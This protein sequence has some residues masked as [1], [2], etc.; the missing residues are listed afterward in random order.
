MS[1]DSCIE[2]IG[3][4]LKN[5]QNW[6]EIADPWFEFIGN[7]KPV[8][9]KKGGWR[10]VFF[11]GQKVRVVTPDRKKEKYVEVTDIIVYPPVDNDIVD[12]PLIRYLSAEGIGN[13]LP[14]ITSM[15]DA[16]AIYKQWSTSEELKTQ[17]FVGIHMKEV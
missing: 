7:K 17:G 16:I 15:N 14:G 8:E 2:S 13:C 6:I 5:P 11:I 12:G 9:G 10:K 1:H 4:H 3:Y